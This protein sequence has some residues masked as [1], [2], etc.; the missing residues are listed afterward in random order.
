M[1]FRLSRTVAYGLVDRFRMCDEFTS[2]EN[3]DI[4]VLCMM[5]ECRNSPIYDNLHELCADK[6]YKT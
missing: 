6:K 1:H 3:L 5:Q 4:Q 2:M